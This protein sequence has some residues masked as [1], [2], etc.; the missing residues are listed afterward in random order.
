MSP[1]AA[2]HV[3]EEVEPDPEVT[4][5]ELREGGVAV[6]VAHHAVDVPAPQPGIG[7]GLGDG[8]DGH[9]PRGPPRVARVL[10]LPDADDAVLVAKRFHGASSPVSP[11]CANGRYHKPFDE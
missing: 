10:R 3:H 2:H 1:V 7:Q 6:L 4:R 5:H 8:I 11:A 9:G